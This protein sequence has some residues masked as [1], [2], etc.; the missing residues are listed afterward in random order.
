MRQK[1]RDMVNTFDV[2][3]EYNKAMLIVEVVSTVLLTDW[4]SKAFD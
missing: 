3:E 1:R 2:Y 4:R